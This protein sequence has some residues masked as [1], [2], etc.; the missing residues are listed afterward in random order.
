LTPAAP[1]ILNSQSSKWRFILIVRPTSA[2]MAKTDTK[3][4]ARNSHFAIASRNKRK[5]R[6][7]KKSNLTNF[8]YQIVSTI[9]E[10]AKAV[11]KHLHTLIL[12]T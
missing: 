3:T 1:S 7:Q 11:N 2:K 10:L 12:Q 8:L 4:Q 9:L 6:Q 5:I